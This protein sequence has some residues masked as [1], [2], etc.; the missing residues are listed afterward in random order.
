MKN[1]TVRATTIRVR[2]SAMVLYYNVC[3]VVLVEEASKAAAMRPHNLACE[4]ALPQTRRHH[5][6]HNS[7]LHHGLGH[8]I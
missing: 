8:C 3:M 6:L 7:A 5:Q 1:D 4:H 2:A